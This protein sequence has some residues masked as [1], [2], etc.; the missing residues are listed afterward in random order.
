LTE[1]ELEVLQLEK[2]MSKREIARTLFLSLNTIRSH[3][4]SI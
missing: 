1:R 4:R 2:G 3:T